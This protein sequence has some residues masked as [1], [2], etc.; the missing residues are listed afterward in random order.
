MEQ[1]NL[2]GQVKFGRKSLAEFIAI[3]QPETRKWFLDQVGY[4]VM[5][6]AKAN[7]RERHAKAK[8]PSRLG[9]GFWAAIADSCSY[10]AAE[11]KVTVGAAHYAAG[12]KQTGGT[13]RAPGKGPGSKHARALTIP[14]HP[15]AYGHS[16]GELS[17]LGIF[18]VGRTL[19]FRDETGQYIALFALVKSVF[20]RP[21]PWFPDRPQVFASVH[22]VL[23]EVDKAR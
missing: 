2:H 21:D 5:L 13:I 4:R 23:N 1:I 6:K 15:L 8:R 20:Q 18:R 3:L 10:V 14:I 9:G 11:A 12:F 22:D 7:A 16:A 17:S 19:G